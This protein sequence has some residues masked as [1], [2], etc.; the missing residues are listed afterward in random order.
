MLQPFWLL[1][2][3]RKKPGAKFSWGCTYDNLGQQWQA[4][5][6]GGGGGQR[7][8]LG[9]DIFSNSVWCHT[10]FSCVSSDCL[11]GLKTI[12]RIEKYILKFSLFSVFIALSF[13]LAFLSFKEVVFSLI[14][15]HYLSCF[16]FVGEKRQ[17]RCKRTSWL[18]GWKGIVYLLYIY[19]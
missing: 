17:A 18:A 12:D 13:Y 16:C 7:A 2:L 10:I 9:I 19:M 5:I 4:L 14:N 6:I 3:V 11:C 15:F 1:H 8:L